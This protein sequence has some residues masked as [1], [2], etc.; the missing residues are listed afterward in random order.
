MKSSFSKNVLRS[1]V[2]LNCCIGSALGVNANALVNARG[3]KSKKV[4]VISDIPESFRKQNV[5]T[6]ENLYSYVK[7][8]VNLIDEEISAETLNF[9]VKSL[10]PLFPND[11]AFR[12]AQ[13]NVPNFDRFIFALG[14][15]MSDYTRAYYD[16]EKKT[17]I[18]KEQTW[19]RQRGTGIA[20]GFFGRWG[21]KK[22]DDLTRSII[23][24]WLKENKIWE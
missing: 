22:V 20:D 2:A 8:T 7:C 23:R 13:K 18:S 1:V 21:Y 12:A 9:F 17:K 5:N 24:I 14:K 6:L 11:I 3:A 19:I 15:T 16:D 10:K 4:T